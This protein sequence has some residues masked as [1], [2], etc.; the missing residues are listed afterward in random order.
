MLRLVLAALVCASVASAAD[1]QPRWH[2]GGHG[3]WH[4]GWGGGGW[5]WQERV[6]PTWGWGRLR[7]DPLTGLLGGMIGGFIG[8]KMAQPDPPPPPAVVELQPFTPDWYDYCRGKF[9]SFDAQT[10][11]YTGYDGGKHFCR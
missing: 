9:Q 8:S 1:A 11:Y 10:G 7:S 6:H 5:G 3:G 2:G 4:G